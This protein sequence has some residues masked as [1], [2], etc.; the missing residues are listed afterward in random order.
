MEVSQLR[1]AIVQKKFG[2]VDT[3]SSFFDSFRIVYSPYYSLWLLDRAEDPVYVSYKDG[4]II[5]FLKLKTEDAGED[6]S[7]I[8]PA[9]SPGRRLKICSL[10]VE[11][12]NHGLSRQLM[13][14]VF[15]SAVREMVSEIYATVAENCIEKDKLIHFL[16]KY[17]FRKYGTK[18]SHGI[19][20][21]V[22][23]MPVNQFNLY[24]DAT[25]DA[26]YPV[27]DSEK[28]L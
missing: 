23:S 6:Y 25:P 20:E 5:G 28:I 14:I 4:R 3:S 13:E 21:D 17:G 16:Q 27:A 8:T 18:F 12:S 10:K 1:Y 22:F 26:D 19:R 11:S 15:D 9:F 24:I 7:D 2:E